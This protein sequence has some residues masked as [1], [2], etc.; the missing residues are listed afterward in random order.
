MSSKN[1]TYL[2]EMT[3]RYVINAAKL[4]EFIDPNPPRIGY[5]IL[6]DE[7]GNPVKPEDL[8]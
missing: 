8:K 2:E 3:E 6:M 4:P 5:I 7:N 1:K